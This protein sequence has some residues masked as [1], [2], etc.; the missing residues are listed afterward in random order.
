MG[1]HELRDR[2]RLP[3]S[4]RLD[5]LDVQLRDQGNIDLAGDEEDAVAVSALPEAVEKYR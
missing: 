5:D 4:H 1:P 3:R 2:A